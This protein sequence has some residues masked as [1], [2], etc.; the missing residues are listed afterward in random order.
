MSSYARLIESVRRTRK[1]L[2]LV[3]GLY[4]AIG[5]VVAATTAVEGNFLGTFLG[6]LMIS[7]ALSVGIIARTA[8]H[9]LVR[10]ASIEES[11]GEFSERVEGLIPLVRSEASPSAQIRQPVGQ[12]DQPTPTLDLAKIGLGDPEVLAAA[13]LDR[14]VYPRLVSSIDE[15]PDDAPTGMHAQS[16]ESGAASGESNGQPPHAGSNGHSVTTKNL[17]HQWKSAM[18]DSD[19]KK[20]RQVL[21]ALVDLVEPNAVA[22]LRTQIHDLEDRVEHSLREQF[23][24]E[25]RGREFTAAI[26][27]GG[28]LC[29]LLPDRP[30]AAEF[31]RLKPI[32]TRRAD[33]TLVPIQS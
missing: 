10:I 24:R 19:L 6:F 5:F 27:T 32:L 11:L 21:S 2:Y 20:C 31:Q 23:S 13:T 3:A 12:S 17:L 4:V 18:A 30:V 15:A 14:D 26:L 7:G 16:R 8:L 9:V 22:P 33:A 29:E 25:V 28:R 1:T